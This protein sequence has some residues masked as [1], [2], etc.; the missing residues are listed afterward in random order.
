MVHS[1]LEIAYCF[2]A[3][4]SFT[5][6][7]NAPKRT[8]VLSSFTAAI[9]YLIYEYF[10]KK[11]IPM[12][13]FFLGTTFVAIIG[14]IFARKLKMPAT[15][16]IFP[17]IIPI[18]PGLGLY[19]TILAFVQDDIPLALETGVS[20]ILNIGCMAVAMAMVSLMTLKIKKRQTN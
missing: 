8:L 6:I 20:T 14:E 3:T 7:M 11:G 15:I 17:G 5:L 18:V 13:G 12:A 9:G 10:I 16:F 4:L 1:I 19:E 2:T